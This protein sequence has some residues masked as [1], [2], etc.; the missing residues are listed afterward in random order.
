METALALDTT[1]WA[2]QNFGGAPLGDARRAKRLVRMCAKLAQVSHGVL[3]QT[4]REWPELK[5]AYRLL[6]N[7]AVTGEA[8]QRPHLDWTRAACLE[9]GTMLL[10]A[11]TTDLNFTRATEMEGLGWAGNPAERGLLVHTTLAVRVERWAPDGTP[12]L[13]L[14]GLYDQ[15]VWT[16]THT[17]RK[18]RETQRERLQR[19]RESQRWGRALFAS[20][21]PPAWAEWIHVADRESD[22]YEVLVGCRD[23]GVSHVIRACWPRKVDGVRGGLLHAARHAPSKGQTELALRARPGQPA[24]TAVLTIRAATLKLHA[25]A[26]P[27]GRGTPLTVN[28]VAAVEENPPPGVKGLDWV[29]V[30]NL[31]VRDVADCVRVLRIYESRWLIEEYHK[32]LKTGLGVEQSQL[33]TAQALRNLLALLA[34]VAVRLVRLKLLGRSAPQRAI[35]A[36]DFPAD[37]IALLEKEYGRPPEGWTGR[38]VLRHLARQGGFLARKGDGEPGWLTIWRGWQRFSAMLHGARLL[39]GA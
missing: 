10:I 34:I 19:T 14:L 8:L 1:A 30:T 3:P 32:A 25:P 6:G 37:G 31:A 35:S 29:L 18:K 21:G 38:Q 36:D 23:T 39:K 16:R 7:A 26:R 28:V 2:E 13:N 20:G 27:G 22:I 12:Q 4:F 17:P 11:D 24:R 5:G 9:Q 15:E 33:E